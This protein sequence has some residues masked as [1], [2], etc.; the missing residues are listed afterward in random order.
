MYDHQRSKRTTVH[1]QLKERAAAERLPRRVTHTAMKREMAVLF[2]IRMQLVLP[3]VAYRLAFA[4][5]SAFIV[6]A[7]E[8]LPVVCLVVLSFREPATGRH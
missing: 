8:E 1:S 6:V 7:I 3:A 4:A 2:S 5:P